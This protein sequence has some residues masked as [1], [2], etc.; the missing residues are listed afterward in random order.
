MYDMHIIQGKT[1]GERFIKVKKLPFRAR[2]LN[3]SN[4]MLSKSAGLWSIQQLYLFYK[5][6]TIL[7]FGTQNQQIDSAFINLMH[8]V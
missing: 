2:K 8:N 6:R 7:P 4:L 1:P 3:F 5:I